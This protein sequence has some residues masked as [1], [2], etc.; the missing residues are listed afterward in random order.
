MG[1]EMPPAGI[2]SRKMATMR[3]GKSERNLFLNSFE[4]GADN[5]YGNG[6]TYTYFPNTKLGNIT[7]FKLSGYLN[8]SVGRSSLNN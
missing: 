4:P 8:K 2:L 3:L 5:S 7:S 6:L 1:K